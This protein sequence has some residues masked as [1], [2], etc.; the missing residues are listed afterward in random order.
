MIGSNLHEGTMFVRPEQ[1]NFPNSWDMVKEMFV[2]NH[3]EAGFARIKDYYE[4]Q[5][6][7]AVSMEWRWL[8]SILPRIMRSR[9]LR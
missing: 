1:T 3:N 4:K 8:S 5:E 9:C 6:M 2:K 7:K